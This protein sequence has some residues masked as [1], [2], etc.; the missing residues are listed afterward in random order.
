MFFP[1]MFT[2]GLLVI[3]TYL[4]HTNINLTRRQPENEAVKR[5]STMTIL[6]RPCTLLLAPVVERTATQH[7]PRSRPA[8]KQ[9]ARADANVC[10]SKRVEQRPNHHSAWRPSS[11]VDDESGLRAAAMQPQCCTAQH[12]SSAATA[13]LLHCYCAPSWPSRCAHPQQRTF[14]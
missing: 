6:S 9:H 7:H 10:P 1:R 8:A 2:A 4:L 11:V 3:D 13:L 14:A 5:V 12:G